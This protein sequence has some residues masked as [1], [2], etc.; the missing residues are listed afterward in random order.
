MSNNKTTPYRLFESRIKEWAF[1]EKHYLM[2]MMGTRP[3]DGWDK[4][5]LQSEI[6]DEQLRNNFPASEL[7]PDAYWIHQEIV[8]K[9]SSYVYTFMTIFGEHVWK[10]SGTL[11]F[12]YFNSRSSFKGRQ[13]GAIGVWIS[14][15]TKRD[16]V[17]EVGKE[18]T[19]QPYSRV[20][21]FIDV[22]PVVSTP[23]LNDVRWFEGKGSVVSSF[24][25]LDLVYRVVTS[26]KSTQMVDVPLQVK[27]SWQST[28]YT[29]KGEVDLLDLDYYENNF[30]SYTEWSF[31][32]HRR[33]AEALASLIPSQF[34]IVAPGDGWGVM[35]AAASRHVVLS[36]DIVLGVDHTE[37]ISVT[38]DRL[39]KNDVLVLSYV[40]NVISSDDKVR[41]L[42]L[43]TPVIVIDAF[44][45]L[46]GFTR[47][48]EGVFSK[49]KHSWFPT[50][51][52]IGTPEGFYEQV[53]HFT[54]NLLL[55]S[56]RS[57]KVKTNAYHY[58][59]ALRPFAQDS[60]KGSIICSTIDEA[61][62]Y[63]S[64]KPYLAPIG[65]YFSSVE[66]TSI[67]VGREWSTRCVYRIS[68]L[69]SKY[70]LHQIRHK[71]HWCF[72]KDFFY[73]CF[74]FPTSIRFKVRTGTSVVDLLVHVREDVDHVSSFY[75]SAVT[76][77]H[78]MWK[79]PTLEPIVWKRTKFSDWCAYLFL[80]NS[81]KSKKGWKKA[82]FNTYSVSKP[83]LS[84]WEEYIISHKL[85]EKGV[86]S[87]SDV[88][89]S[90]DDLWWTHQQCEINVQGKGVLLV[91]TFRTVDYVEET[92]RN[93]YG[94]MATATDTGHLVDVMKRKGWRVPVSVFLTTLKPDK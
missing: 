87:F 55:I 26:P 19:P 48:G 17:L 25:Y 24:S 59:K 20:S 69:E 75:L 49:F 4:F 51:G 3:G 60:K 27:L 74:S 73:F 86:P 65:K 62:L 67:D 2:T 40:W 16:G 88:G 94:Q 70:I 31:Q 34:R 63:V 18:I 64:E 56:T 85:D 54:E 30:E 57:P 38:L 71:S 76:P 37:S 89:L 77:D 15:Y 52:L 23:L 42:N 32:V 83:D 5:C 80:S 29:V 21:K 93:M 72:D 50:S 13:L 61:L 36:T 90:F 1:T 66:D 43:H 22:F 78:L 6:S 84:E 82:I 68:A 14:L 10:I 9:D 12:L 41:I 45:F 58:H 33:Q 28:Y 81:Q 11:E 8:R 53:V 39:E 44:P 79:G 47:I 7:I 35:K 92:C 91:P 46:Y